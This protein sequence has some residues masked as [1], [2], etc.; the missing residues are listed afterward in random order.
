[1]I[2]IS[3]LNEKDYSKVLNI[4]KKLFINPMTLSELYKFSKQDCFRI[5][6]I[7]IGHIIGYVSFFK[8]KD[9]VEI[10]KIGIEKYYQRKNYGSYL[11]SQMKRTGIKRIFLEVSVENIEAINFYLKN[12]FY[13]IGIRKKYYK[14]KD[15]SSV[16][17]FTFSLKF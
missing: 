14:Q 12:G 8:I 13:K 9:E 1:M 6:K 11:I 2:K 16:D 17:A 4:E 3:C 7:D 15:G 10:I 5:W